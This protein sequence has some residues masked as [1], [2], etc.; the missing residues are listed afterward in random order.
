MTTITV[1]CPR[2]PSSEARIAELDPY[3]DHPGVV[4]VSCQR[5]G[6]DFDVRPTPDGY[7]PAPITY[8]GDDLA[9]DD[10][11]VLFYLPPWSEEP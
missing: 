9:T 3:P 1:D 2:C 5:C 6:D 10:Q 8:H 7:R 11:G 4:L